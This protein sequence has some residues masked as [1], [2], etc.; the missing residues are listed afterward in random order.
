MTT[1]TSKKA[2]HGEHLAVLPLRVLSL[3]ELAY[4][5][6]HLAQTLP[7]GESD[8]AIFEVVSLLEQRQK[9][10]EEAEDAIDDRGSYDEGYEVGYEEGY[11]AGLADLEGEAM[12]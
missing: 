11:D 5:Y 10:L 4:V 8:P 9:E 3:S 1:E 2:M 7:Q 12:G 6:A